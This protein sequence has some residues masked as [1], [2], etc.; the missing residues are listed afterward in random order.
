[1]KMHSLSLGS[2]KYG[3]KSPRQLELTRMIV[4]GLI[5]D[6]GLPL[7]IVEHPA[8]LRAMNTIDPKFTVLSR[9]SL[10]REALPAALEQIMGKVKE[11]CNEA[12]FVALTLDL[13]SDRRMRT[14]IG[15]TMHTI[16]KTDNSFKNYLLIFQPLESKLLNNVTAY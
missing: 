13:W 5:I 6:L 4:Q 7:S 3:D 14:F 16:S 12:Q 10:C 8:F 2:L 15:I 11:A 1:M 9:R